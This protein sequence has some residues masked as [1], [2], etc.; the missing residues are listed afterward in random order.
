MRPGIGRTSGL[1]SSMASGRRAHKLMRPCSSAASSQRTW[2]R[3]TSAILTGPSSS[4]GRSRRTSGE[5]P[6]TCMANGSS[7]EHAPVTIPRHYDHDDTAPASS[8]PS[9]TTSSRCIYLSLL[10]RLDHPLFT[11]VAVAVPFAREL[12]SSIR[13]LALSPCPTMLSSYPPLVL[14]PLS[15]F[16]VIRAY[17]AR[18]TPYPPS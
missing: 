6:R 13:A 12:S 8:S 5:R 7:G 4:S 17:P 1:A 11:A 10:T 18:T 9:H 2:W 15:Q 16:D 14:Y 3:T